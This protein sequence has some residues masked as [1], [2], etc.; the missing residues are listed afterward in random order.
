MT[1]TNKINAHSP[2]FI[3]VSIYCGKYLV[4]IKAIASI[5]EYIGKYRCSKRKGIG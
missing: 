3:A 5:D 1:E 2:Y 4:Q